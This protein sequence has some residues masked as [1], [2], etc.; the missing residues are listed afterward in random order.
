MIYCFDIDGTVCTNT[1]G[2]Y[3]KAEPFAEV[4]AEVNRLFAQGHR[5]ILYTARGSTTGI[6]W[7]ELT[8]SQLRRWGVCYHDLYT[9]K[10]TAD[11]YID[12]KAINT[13]DWKRCGFPVE[14]L[15]SESGSKFGADVGAKSNVRENPR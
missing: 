1:E 2:D 6:N 7:R 5:I 9:G 12:D 3:S 10:P 13:H 8:E 14:L 11:I 4:I 15:P